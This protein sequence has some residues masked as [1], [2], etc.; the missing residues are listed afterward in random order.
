MKNNSYMI[1]NRKVPGAVDYQEIL[2]LTGREK[3]C[4]WWY[5]S[6]CSVNDPEVS[7][8]TSQSTSP[9]QIAPAPFLNSLIDQLNEQLV[10]QLTIYIHGLS[11][12]W[13]KAVTDTADLG[14]GLKRQGY[15]GIVLGFSWPSYNWK[16]SVKHYASGNQF[17]PT[18]SK[19]TV[20]DNIGGSY[21]SFGSLL[22][23]LNNLESSV[24]GLT[25][26]FLC[27]SEGNYMMMT[28]MHGRT[29]DK[30]NQVL[31]I[32][33]DINNA[34]LQIPPPN[35]LAGQGAGIR[36]N[37]KEV[38]VYYSACDTMLA[39]SVY[40]SG[41][42]HDHYHN[43]DF[44][45]RLGTVGPSY[46]YALQGNNIVGLDCSLVINNGN[47]DKLEK[48][49]IVPAKTDLHSSYLYVPQILED[50]VQTIANKPPESISN[51]KAARGLNTN[52]YVMEPVD[53]PTKAN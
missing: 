2:P 25:I 34:A 29:E 35:G 17:P 14:S 19:G 5:M 45:G 12:H 4:L 11:I 37:C 52:S 42:P 38:T 9:E 44:G 41:Q 31:L 36:E 6:E 40:E 10:P 23:F 46:D 43:P 47:V 26:N 27:H 53:K 3:Q 33:A 8:F 22:S 39:Y 13:A 7:N 1:T 21:E 18:K 32:A 49:G 15:E 30:L 48:K 20:R 51:R 16:A 24:K 28:G 50:I